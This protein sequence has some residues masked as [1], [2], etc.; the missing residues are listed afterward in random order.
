MQSR[1]P[2][3]PSKHPL[4]A[5]AAPVVRALQGKPLGCCVRRGGGYRPGSVRSHTGTTGALEYPYFHGC[6]KI[7]AA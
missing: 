5:E 4:A 7:S 1:S 2:F 6:A 3:D